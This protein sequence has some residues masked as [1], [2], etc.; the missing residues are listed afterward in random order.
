MAYYYNDERRNYFI[1]FGSGRPVVL[2]HGISNSG[3]AWAPQIGPLVEAGFRVVIPDHA[4]HGAS[5]K[6]GHPISVTDLALD[7]QTLLD[8]LKLDEVDIVGLSLGGMV[9]LEA[10][11]TMP[12]RVRRLVVANS[13]DTTA[14]DAFRDMAQGWAA[15]FRSEDGPARRLEGIWPMN[16]NE[17][18]RASEEGMRTYQVW[19]GIAATGDGHSIAC[20]AEGIVGFDVR[21][22]LS[23][24]AMP[25]LFI[26]GAEDRMSPPARSRRMADAV[27]SSRYIEIA[28]AAHISNVDST[29]DFNAAVISFL[30]A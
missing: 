2:L 15:T 12:H 18:F 17:A 4:G 28:G 1:E 5:A 26:A 14:T 6:I 10:A 22:R 9:A 19:H 20:V 25:T 29:A 30:M 13:F 7:V 21:E 11:L 27:P 24:L 8:H 16:V 3:R 23:L